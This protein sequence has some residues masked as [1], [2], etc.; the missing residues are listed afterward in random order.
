MKCVI[1]GGGGF[2]ASHLSDALLA[3]KHDVHV[4][5]RTEARY[6]E[7][8]RQRGA[9]IITGDFSNRDDIRRA[10][11]NCDVIYHLISA[12]VPQTSNDD[13]RNDVEANV[14]STLYLL[15]E[16]RK[17]GGKKIVFVSSGGT[18]YGVPQAI[19]IKE[20]HP[21]EPITSYGICKLIIEKYLHLYWTLY[22][23]KYC[24]LRV[25]NA[26]GERQP[27]TGS[28]GVIAT[29]LDKA[30]RQDE[31]S[32]WGDGSVIRDYVYAG[33]VARALGKAAVYSGEMKVFN[34][35][36]GQ[37][38]SLNEVIEVIEQIVQK[39]LRTKNTSGRVFDVPINVLDISS[40]K[41][42]LDW[43]PTVSLS[44][45]IARE[46]EWMLNENKKQ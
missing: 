14:L 24:V 25:A 3:E 41:L 40:A 39:P 28:Q 20:N 33:D 8:S 6:L 10:I 15:D 22:G 17:A 34:I 12:T 11:L 19:P 16:A 18:V 29:F 1:M 44:E 42:Y 7:Y 45:G 32:V 31:L 27:I 4:F 38:H 36:A 26:Y 5:D 35:G 23:L 2:I 21:T 37:G 30:L 13:P 46:Y 43:Q 9:D